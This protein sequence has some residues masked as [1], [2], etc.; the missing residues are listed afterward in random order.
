MQDDSDR[1]LVAAVLDGNDAATVTLIDRHDTPMSCVAAA[2]LADAADVA[3]VVQESWI[4]V[5]AGLGGF[6]FRSSLKT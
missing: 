2:I 6:E 5:L 1:A 4:R 3:D